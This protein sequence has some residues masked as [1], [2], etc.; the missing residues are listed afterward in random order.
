MNIILLGYMASGKS[1]IGQKLAKILNYKYVDLDDFIE[2]KEKMSV[3]KNFKENG[4]LYFRRVEH[5]YLKMLLNNSEQTIIALGG[6]TPCYY[7]TM[8]LLKEK[9]NFKTIYLKV[10]ISE[11]VNRLKIE[12]FK[13]PLIAH[14]ETEELLT[15]FIG[16]HL[17][18]RNPYYSQSDITIDA[19]PDSNIVVESILT[20]LF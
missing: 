19:N 20:K 3:K 8:S 7:D 17:F 9:A 4:E 16:K 6:G 10:A 5:Q 18:E 15:E 11:L 13:R 2:E 12:K 1:L 14:I